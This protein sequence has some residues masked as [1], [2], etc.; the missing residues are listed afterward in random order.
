MNPELTVYESPESRERCLEDHVRFLTSIA[1]LSDIGISVKTVL[2]SSEHDV[3]PSSEAYE[4]ICSDGIGILPL[5]DFGGMVIETG[6]YPSNK[7]LAD[8]LCFPDGVLEIEE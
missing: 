8:Y 2:I 3:D 4:M 5:T 7:V 6:E 1:K